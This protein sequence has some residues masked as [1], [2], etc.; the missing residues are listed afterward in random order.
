MKKNIIKTSNLKFDAKKTKKIIFNKFITEKN[1][2]LFFSL[3]NQKERER[4]NYKFSMHIKNNERKDIK[5]SPL[6]VRSIK[7]KKGFFFEIVNKKLKKKKN[8]EIEMMSS[9]YNFY[10]ILCYQYEI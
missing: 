6:L 8:E 5:Y 3:L 2:F 10:F 4:K 7:M 1:F 9:R